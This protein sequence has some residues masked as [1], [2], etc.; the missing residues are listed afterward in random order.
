AQRAGVDPVK[1]RRIT[2]GNPFLVVE[3]INAEERPPATVRAAALARAGRLSPGARQVVDAAAVVG[4]RF[5]PQLLEAVAPDSSSAVE[6]ALG[7]GVMVADGSVL[8]FRHELIR[9]ALESLIPPPRRA[10][11]HARVVA[12]L[13]ST[14]DNARLAHHAEL[15][16]LTEEAC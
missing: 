6:E 2:G 14:G 11:L 13:A 15:A 12:A 1:L 5:E 4:Q 16:G 10:K 8:G 9:E 3:S 7:Y